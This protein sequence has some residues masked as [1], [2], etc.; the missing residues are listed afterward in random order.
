[1][2]LITSLISHVLRIVAAVWSAVIVG[3]NTEKNWTTGESRVTSCCPRLSPTE[4]PAHSNQNRSFPAQANRWMHDPLSS[5]S[6]DEG[7]AFQSIGWPA[8]LSSD[9]MGVPSKSSMDVRGKWPSGSLWRIGVRPCCLKTS[10]WRIHQFLTWF[11]TSVNVFK[12]CLWSQSLAFFSA[13]WCSFVKFWPPS[14]YI[15]R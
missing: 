1:M 13:V 3:R 6:E 5:I 7:F 15:W 11:L 4:T 14:F 9:K 10:L 8:M 12:M 2:Y